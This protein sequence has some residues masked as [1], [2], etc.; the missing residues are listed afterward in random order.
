MKSERTFMSL[1]MDSK[2]LAISDKEDI[3]PERAESSM[4]REGRWEMGD[5]KK[6]KEVALS[7]TGEGKET[8][9]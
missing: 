3:S 7:V 4:L 2:H 6:R 1:W 5:G 8:V 9:A